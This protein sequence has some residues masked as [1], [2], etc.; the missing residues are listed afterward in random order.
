MGRS[1]LA[2]P[3][4]TPA[5]TRRL[6][7]SQPVDQSVCSLLIRPAHLCHRPAAPN[8]ST[9]TQHVWPAP[10]PHTTCGLSPKGYVF[11]RM[12]EGLTEILLSWNPRFRQRHTAPRSRSCTLLKGWA[13][14]DLLAGLSLSA[15][16]TTARCLRARPRTTR[17]PPLP[18][19]RRARRLMSVHTPTGEQRHIK[20]QFGLSNI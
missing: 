15:A 12:V 19:C 8:D 20:S 7:T 6:S 10:M 17:G 18:V 1:S 2:T 9:T 14:A 3:S 13:S 16:H 11:A 5:R 4:S